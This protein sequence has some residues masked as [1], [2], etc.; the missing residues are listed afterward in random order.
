MLGSG[1]PPSLVNRIQGTTGGGTT[2]AS[3]GSTGQAA[4]PAGGTTAASSQQ[5][6]RALLSLP[7]SGSPVPFR[8]A[9]PAHTS[10]WSL[11][12][13]LI[14]VLAIATLALSVLAFAQRRRTSG[15]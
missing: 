14:I 13:G 9:P 15:A 12:S 10:N 11:F 8:A 6:R 3:S 1:L 2:G 5:V 7:A 4:A